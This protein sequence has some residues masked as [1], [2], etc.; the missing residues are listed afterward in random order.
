MLADAGQA[1]SVLS[2]M[3]DIQA[4]PHITI[5]DVD[6]IPTMDIFNDGKVAFTLNNPHGQSLPVQLPL[7]SPQH[8]ATALLA[9]T[10][11]YEEEEDMEEED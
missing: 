6:T 10:E 2:P 4:L 7:P 11:T 5:I 3:E 1:P 8:Q 9:L